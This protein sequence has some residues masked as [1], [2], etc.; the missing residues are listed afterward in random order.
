MVAKAQSAV[1]FLSTYSFAL[2]MIT[3]ALLVAALIAGAR[4]SGLDLYSAC[5]IE[6]LL[7]CQQA[8]LSYNPSSP[9]GAYS[10]FTLLFKNQLGYNL[11][12]TANSL[13][14]TTTN[15]GSTGRLYTIG[16]CHPGMAGLGAEVVCT[17]TVRGANVPSI[18][19][20]VLTPFL[21][22]YQL[23]TS[24]NIASCSGTANVYNTTGYSTETLAPI[25]TDLYNFSITSNNGI[26]Y[27]NGAPYYSGTSVY[28]V[29]G[30][31]PIYAQPFGTHTF[32]SW[33]TVPSTSNFMITNTIASNSFLVL[34]QNGNVIA[35][36]N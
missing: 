32:A 27:V 24:S 17:A 1:E 35:N 2:V 31:Y 7:P 30:N 19:T 25:N 11:N 8:V 33:S 16:K 36:F 20:S 4:G 3:I 14:L 34:K 15:I 6:P 13:N 22:S 10:N 29:T 18:G 26:V 28:L 12:F 23:C 9:S 5:S 21:I